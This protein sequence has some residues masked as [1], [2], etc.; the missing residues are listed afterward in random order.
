[1]AEVT[2]DEEKEWHAITVRNGDT[3]ATIFKRLALNQ[4]VLHSLTQVKSYQNVINKIFP[5][6]QLEFSIANGEL[7]GFKAHL[8]QI[9][10]VVFEKKNDAGYKAN[11]IV[12]VPEIVRQYRHAEIK[13][14]LFTAGMEAGLSHTMILELAN[15]L[16]G[17]IDFALD[18]RKGDAIDI[19]YEE[20]WLDGQKVGEGDILAASQ[21]YDR[22]RYLHGVPLCRSQWRCRLLLA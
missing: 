13:H 19:I 18:P 21:L 8:S 1:M 4:T 6:Q 9:E 14:S 7:L 22:H 10:T 2:A 12:R 3:M 11:K 16:G 5:G 15:V 17:E 20:K